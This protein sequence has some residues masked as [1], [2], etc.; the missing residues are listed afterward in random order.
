MDIRWFSTTSASGGV[1]QIANLESGVWDHIAFWGSEGPSGDVALTDAQDFTWITDNNGV[2]SGE[3]SVAALVNNKWVDASGVQIEGGSRVDLSTV[4]SS[5][6]GTI[7]IEVSGASAVELSNTKLFAYDASDT[8]NNP[9]GIYV[10]TY[11]ILGSTASGTG[12]T[13][14]ALIDATNHNRFVDR[15]TSIGYDSTNVYDYIVG[16]SIRPQ[17]GETSGL[18]NFAFLFQTDFV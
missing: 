5:G 6:S 9:S 3:A 4:V 15:T 8:G 14:W 17:A 18:A 2:V 7:R 12:D 16:V 13:Q 10:L 1:H 11:E